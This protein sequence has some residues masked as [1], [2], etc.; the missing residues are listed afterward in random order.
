M[1]LTLV[2]GGNKEGE[3]NTMIRFI[4]LLGVLNKQMK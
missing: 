4:F 3:G 1:I 2:V